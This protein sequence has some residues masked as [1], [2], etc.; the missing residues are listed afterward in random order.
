MYDERPD[1]A[2]TILIPSH[3]LSREFSI[4]RFIRKEDRNLI[5]VKVG[6][7]SKWMDLCTD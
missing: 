6:N 2:T 4:A 5:E 7:K 1:R 3:S